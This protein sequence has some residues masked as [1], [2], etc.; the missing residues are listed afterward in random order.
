M[1]SGLVVEWTYAVDLFDHAT[2]VG[3]GD[4]FRRVLDAVVAGPELVVGDIDLLDGGERYWLLEEWWGESRWVVGDATVVELFDARVAGDRDA[5][6]VVDGGV[7]LSYGQLDSRANRFARQLISWGVGPETLV[8]VMLPR[9]V[10]LVV[11]VLRGAEGGWGIRAGRPS[12]PGESDR[13]GAVGFGACGGGDL[14][15]AG[16]RV[17]RAAR[18]VDVDVVDWSSFDDGPVRDGERRA[19]LRPSSAAYVIYTSGST[20]S[21][22]GGGDSAFERGAVDGDTQES[23]GFDSSDVW[24]LFHSFAFDFSVWELWGSL[25]YGGTLVVVDYVT[26]RSPDQ[27]LEL[28]RGQGVTVLNQTPSAFYQLAEADR[29]TGSDGVG[30]AELSL[31]YVIFGGEALDVR[32]LSGWFARHGDSSPRLVNMYGIT[33]T[34]VHVTRIEMD[35]RLVAVEASPVGGPIAGLRVYLLDERLHPVPVGV[36]GELY[37]AGDQVARGYLH[38]PDLSVARFVANPFG[39]AGSRFYRSGDV[40]RWSADGRLEFVGR[41]DDQVKVRGFRIELAEVEA[42]VLA[43]SL[44]GH[45]AVIVREDNPGDKRLVAYVVPQ[46]ASILDVSVLR[47]GCVGTDPGLHGAVGVRGDRFDSVDRQREVGS[48]WRC[49]RRC[50]RRGCFGR[51]RPRWRRSWPTRSP[52]CWVRRGSVWTTISSNSVATR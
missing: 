48:T 39:R 6:A 24:T 7:V 51:R 12:Y 44:V 36:A 17:A 42:A 19:A 38:R 26:S 50:S 34:T 1:A 52:M 37:V 20:G 41:A 14:E 22:Q 15:W 30:V 2:I 29:V 9:S 33:E 4:R 11:A 31:R 28:L 18:V 16:G 47:A 32:R 3:F 49:L 25:L 8:A 10:D 27:F 45:A 43:Q 23:F 46:A 5:R 21:A 35:A 40:A 13:D